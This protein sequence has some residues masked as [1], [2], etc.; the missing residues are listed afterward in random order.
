MGFHLGKKFEKNNFLSDYTLHHSVTVSNFT[1]HLSLNITFH[2]PTSVIFPACIISLNRKLL[3]QMY[4]THAHVYI[5]YRFVMYCLPMYTKFCAQNCRRF[6]QDRN[7]SVLVFITLDLNLEMVLP[8]ALFIC[9]TRP[10]Y[11]FNS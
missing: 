6:L 8:D 11:L 9:F 10:I 3:I 1:P 7:F 2:P 4:N 5:R